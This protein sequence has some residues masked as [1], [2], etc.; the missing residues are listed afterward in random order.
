[1]EFTKVWHQ[2]ESFG[3]SY[4]KGH[5]ASTALRQAP[6]SVWDIGMRMSKANQP[7]S[8]AI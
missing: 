1:M 5:S 6:A 7:F 2:I 8:Y 3:Y 4:A